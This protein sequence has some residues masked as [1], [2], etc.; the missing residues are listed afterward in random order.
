M[1]IVTYDNGAANKA[2]Q[3]GV[4]S[5]SFLATL[6]WLVACGLISLQEAEDLEVRATARDGW[7]RPAAQA[8]PLAA[9]IESLC[10]ALGAAL[11]AVKPAGRK[12]RR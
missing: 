3:Y 9:Q 5:V 1:P 6:A 11:N 7:V 2:Q 8:G 10:S 12:P 4:A